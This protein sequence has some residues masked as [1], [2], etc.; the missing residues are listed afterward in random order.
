MPE[1]TE[2]EQAALE[3]KIERERQQKLNEDLATERIFADTIANPNV[4]VYDHSR[5]S[6]IRK[7]MG[8]TLKASIEMNEL[9]KEEPVENY[10]NADMLWKQSK[11][12]L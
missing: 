7:Y 11:K 5:S 8:R 10:F 9:L 6:L 12:S 2:E 1:L 4:K 3:E